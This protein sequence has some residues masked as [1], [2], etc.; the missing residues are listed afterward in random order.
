MLSLPIA[1]I[2]GEREVIEFD[3]PAKLSV[4]LELPSFQLHY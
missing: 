2:P 3:H 4:A 1:G